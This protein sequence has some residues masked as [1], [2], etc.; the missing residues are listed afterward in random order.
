MGTR[1]GE[2]TASAR[3]PANGCR[4]KRPA[5]SWP[6]S[7][8][9]PRSCRGA[10]Q[11]SGCSARP[12]G[13][14]DGRRSG[15][16]GRPA[17][18][19]SSRGRCRPAGPRPRRKPPPIRSRRRGRIQGPTH[20]EC[21]GSSR[22][23]LLTLRRG[24]RTRGSSDATDCHEARPG[25]IPVAS[26]SAAGRGQAHS[27]SSREKRPLIQGSLAGPAPSMC[28]SSTGRRRPTMERSGPLRQPVQRQRSN[29]VEDVGNTSIEAR[30]EQLGRE[31]RG[32]RISSGFH[33]PTEKRLRPVAMRMS[34][35]FLRT[36]REDPA[37]AEVPSHR[38]LVR[39]GYIRRAAPGIYS[40]LPLGWTRAAP[41]RAHRPRGDGR[42]RRAG[43]A[44][45]GAAAAR[46]LRGHRPLDRLRRQHLP[47]ART[48]RAP[49][50]CS[51]RP[52]RRCSRC[53]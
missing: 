16:E 38:L 25:S 9:K 18:A 19:P 13:L 34:S 31:A 42:D 24:R 23:G 47:A 11:P 40:W 48:A 26:S 50:T 45:P 2:P 28:P 21:A 41:D 33:R 36:L 5:A 39:A 37:D 20:P 12:P 22:S 4:R 44:L 15:R 17:V 30:R 51:G 7:G 29:L 10:R 8:P 27:A 1:V 14:A 52:T 46:A 6:P 35:L 53:W 3:S 49:T 43:G 32:G